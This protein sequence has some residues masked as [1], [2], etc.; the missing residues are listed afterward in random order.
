M[1]LIVGG[2][3]GS[4][5]TTIGKLLAGRLGWEFADADDFHSAA[6]IAKMR[7]GH[8]LSDSDRFPWL[9]AIG[10]WMDTE[11]AA[12]RS[13]IVA[14]SALARRY[15]EALLH[16]RDEVRIVF[17]EISREEAFERLHRRHGHFFGEQM[18]TSQFAELEAPAPDERT[19]VV[20]SDHPPDEMVDEI[21]GLLGLG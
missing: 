10:A 4:G 11:N 2:V 14:C 19:Y 13:A 1:M 20:P 7:S 9:T 17:L 3:A 16:G 18:V 12:G 8:P 15:R 6:N 5:K 21:I